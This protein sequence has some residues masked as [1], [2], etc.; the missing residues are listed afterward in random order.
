M[1]LDGEKLVEHGLAAR[2]SLL[3][4]SQGFGILSSALFLGE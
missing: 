1:D 4:D 3:M 2:H